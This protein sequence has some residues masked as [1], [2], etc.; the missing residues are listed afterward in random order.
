MSSSEVPGLP[1]S[2]NAPLDISHDHSAA[3]AL[4]ERAT[5]LTIH[6][7]EVINTGAENL[8]I[9]VN[10]EWVF[11]LPRDRSL[12]TKDRKQLNFLASFSKRSPLGVPD[13]VYVT[14]DFVGYKRSR[15][16]RCIRRRLSYCPGKA[17][18][19]FRNNWACSWQRSIT[20][21]TRLSIS[22]LGI[23]SCETASTSRALRSSPGIFAPVKSGNSRP[24]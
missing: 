22:I 6:T 11:R 12:G 5:G 20:I 23:C 2:S 17:R 8:I 15:G 13:P 1:G 3:T 9:E 24:S 19:R 4:I 18:N 16:L 21:K 14:D 7:Y 10:D